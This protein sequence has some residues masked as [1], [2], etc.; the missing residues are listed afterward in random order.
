MAESSSVYFISDVHLGVDTQWTSQ[1]REQALI[2]W[3]NSVKKDASTI[4]IVGDLFDYWYE[5]NSV[6]P[7]GYFELFATM[8]AIVDR[9]VK[10]I[11]L[12]GNHDLW[13]FG[14]LS[15]HIGIDVISGPIIES[16]DN[17]RFYITHGDG[18]GKGDIGYKFIKAILSNRLCQRLFGALHP[19]LGLPLMKY[20]SNKSRDSHSAEADST[21]HH[22][23]FCKSILANQA[24]IDF[25]VMGHL[26]HP[27][28]TDLGTTQ[29]V[30][31]GDWTSAFTYAQSTGT[32]LQL[33]KWDLEN[34]L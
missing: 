4:Y 9:G 8:K 17:H 10:L 3:F 23:D 30:N 5:Y 27:E 13:H 11:Y 32:E 21:A 28:I 33:K 15:T 19:T 2:S 16:H 12:P 7:K 6:V 29:Y 22:H 24:D 25:F 26:H 34:I 14:Y 31:L 20:M 1:Q 18:I